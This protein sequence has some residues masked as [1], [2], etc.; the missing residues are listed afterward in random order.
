MPSYLGPHFTAAD[1]GKEKD[2]QTPRE[3]EET[4]SEQVQ[5]VAQQPGMYTIV[6]DVFTGL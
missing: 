1:S 3:N 5:E 4:V 2:K 6:M